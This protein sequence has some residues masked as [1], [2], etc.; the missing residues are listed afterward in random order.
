MKQNRVRSAAAVL[1][2][3]IALG[4]AA[5]SAQA[6]TIN[7]SS[8]FSGT[9]GSSHIDTNRDGLSANTQVIG[10]LGGPFG[11][12]TIEALDES[13]PAGEGICANGNPGVLFSLLIADG[14][15]GSFI[16]RFE[17][18]GDLLYM[19]ETAGI[20]CA[21]ANGALSFE[22]SGTINGGTGR[23]SRATGTF[24]MRGTGNFLFADESDSFGGQQGTFDQTIILPN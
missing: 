18:S 14:A 11:R 17:Q 23:F 12:S 7:A 19:T 1:A 10:L 9:F 24:K 8:T 4:F 20:G 15:P 22:A 13:V 5:S 6:Q 21:D 3:T 2:T 16:Q